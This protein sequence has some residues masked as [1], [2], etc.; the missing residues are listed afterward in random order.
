[1]ETKTKQLLQGLSRE[2]LKS[3]IFFLAKKYY[4]SYRNND[5]E[6]YNLAIE[7]LYV[8][9]EEY[10]DR[11]VNLNGFICYSLYLNANVEIMNGT[12]QQGFKLDPLFKMDLL[13]DDVEE[14][15]HD[16]KNIF[17]K[18]RIKERYNEKRTREH[19]E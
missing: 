15:T 1:M 8:I 9:L 4:E 7:Q 6:A 12:E 11:Y 3:Y 5:V 14:L 2:K 16:I 18:E 19:V 17:N 10:G 13:E